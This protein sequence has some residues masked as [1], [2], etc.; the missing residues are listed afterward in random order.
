[1]DAEVKD[2]IIEGASTLFAENGIKSITMD[3]LAQYLGM[4]K[5]T[6]YEYF[7]DK[8]SLVNECMLHI[9]HTQDQK[10]KEIFDL[11]ENMFEA[12]IKMYQESLVKMQVISKKFIEDIK[13]YFPEIRQRHEQKKEERICLSVCFFQKGID[14][15]LI[16]DELNPEILSIL[17][18]TEM[19]LLFNGNFSVSTKFSFFDVYKTLFITF[20]RGI[21][22]AKGLAIMDNYAKANK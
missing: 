8:E 18:S 16:R 10:M 13:K 12:L 15:G 19:E 17:I 2:R 3:E 20:L 11:S 9:E 5:R 22:T 7:K 1:M 21:A 14:E 4:S 6:I